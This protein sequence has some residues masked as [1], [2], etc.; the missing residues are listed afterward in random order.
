VAL[1]LAR[2]FKT[3]Q[4][5][6]LVADRM[7]ALGMLAAGVGHE[8]NNPLMAVLGNLELAQQDVE[9][10]QQNHT[11][12]PVGD[13]PETL[14]DAH[15]AAGRMRN[16]VRDLKLFSRGDDDTRGAVDVGPVI[17][18]SL[19]IVSHELK[20]RATLVRDLAPVPLVW[21]NEARLGQVFLNIIVNAVHALPEDRA[22]TNELRVATS[23]APDGRVR[24]QIA[25]NGVGMS[26]D[27]VSR[28]FTP[29]FT[30]KPVGVGTGLG[31]AICHQL[32]TSVGG[33]ITVD[34]KVGKG[35]TFNVF[36]PPS[37]KGSA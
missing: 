15:E 33:E 1:A 23:I 5:Q 21:G 8:I 22:R 32:V 28:I 2:S 36:L 6:L 3:A 31:L 20:Y 16:I 37:D 11:S 12:V 25:D 30:T 14:R 34:T 9:T 35:T 24:V 18:S 4:Q 29:F 17:E 26:P 27:V 7:A 19:R 10:L 13:L